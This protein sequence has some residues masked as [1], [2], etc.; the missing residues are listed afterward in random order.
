MITAGQC[1]AARALLNWSR[2]Q[3]AE[4]SRVSLR[5]IIEHERGSHVLGKVTLDSLRRTLE[6]AGVEF[7]AENDKGVGVRLRKGTPR[8]NPSASIKVEN[9]NA[10]NDE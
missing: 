6:S 10:E 7:L 5:T 2:E 3:L 9:L 1:R 4:V 8:G